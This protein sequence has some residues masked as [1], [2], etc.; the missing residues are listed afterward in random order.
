MKKIVTIP[1]II[2]FIRILL[3]PVFIILYFEKS[4]QNN[5]VWATIILL[6]SGTTDVIDGIIARKFNMIST[7][8]KMIDPVADK[9]T[10]AAV[11]VCLSITHPQI[12]PLMVLF[13]S[14]EFT[15]LLGSVQ[16]YKIGR[17]PSES[18]WWGK[19]ATVVFY[20]MMLIII[21]TDIYWKLP[22]D[23]ISTMVVI[24][25]ISILFSLFNYYPIFKDIQT[26]KY[27]VTTEKRFKNPQ[28]K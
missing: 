13:F 1:N 4:V 2:S 5:L 17:R 28:D 20:F 16:L 21:I 6:I 18:K 12:I 15:M 19:L 25:A 23:A 22:E 26:G 10:Q 11:V 9:L 7:F 3:V 14:K 24:S 8:G 27:D